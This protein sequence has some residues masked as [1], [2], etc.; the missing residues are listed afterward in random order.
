[1]LSSL[2]IALYTASI[3]ED[4]RSLHFTNEGIE[5]I[6]GFCCRRFLEE[7]K[8][9][10][11]RINPEDR[12]RV[13]GELGKVFETGV[14]SLEYRWRCDDDRERFIFDQA[15]LM[16]DENGAPRE[17]FGMWLD[18]TDRKTLEQ[19]LHHASKLEAIGQLT[20]G[21]AH[22]FNNML[23][24]VV[25]NLD[26]LQ[27]AVKGNERA[28]RQARLAMEGAQ[29][30]A[31]LT[32]RLLAFSRRQPLQTTT[33]DLRQLMKGM[34]E[35]L[36]R[37]LGERIDVSLESDD[38]LWPVRADVS[39]LE[40]AI[41]NLAVNA[42]DAMPNGGRLAIAMRNR[43]ADRASSG[44]G[45]SRG[46]LVEIAVAD[47]G[48]G[49]SPAVLE[50][51]FEPFF[52]TKESGKGTGL[53]LSMVYGFVHQ[54]NGDIEIT[55]VLN[56]GTTV[57]I[58]L[59]RAEGIGEAKAEPDAPEALV[60]GGGATVLVVED[61]ANVRQVAVSTLESLGFLVREAE[62]AEEAAS[63]L[64]E[65]DSIALVLSDVRMPG[66]I[67]G[68][69]L[70]RM[71]KRDWPGVGVLLTSGY[72]DEDSDIGDFAFLQKPYRTA[73]LAAKLRGLIGS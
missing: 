6:T 39:Q 63:V 55:S 45:E 7:P 64:K 48:T 54:S 73:D 8:F 10:E 70:G 25:G 51:V 62:S 67:T 59:P 3:Q 29:R 18:I 49:M 69:E 46:D 33:V 40:S 26:L 53:G 43:K 50:R 65:D 2:P 35:L 32:S 66:A 31:D 27:G 11:D 5:K 13:L 9:W 1:V 28:T 21:I 47:E 52:T 16:R 30:C 72:V 15:V 12:S 38:A 23:S 14:A 20:G 41:V 17:I 19:N 22:D 60:E 61:D 58:L 57:R 44:G 56:Q 68:I 24:V 34:L 37:T 36:Q 71:V 42:R 4:H